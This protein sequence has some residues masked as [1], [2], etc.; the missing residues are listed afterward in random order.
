M[1]ARVVVQ[2]PEVIDW[3]G[4]WSPTTAY[5]PGDTVERN[6]SSYRAKDNTTGDD[7]E[8]VPAKWDLLAAKGDKGDQGDPGEPGTPGAP[9]SAPQAFV[10]EQS[11]AATIWIIPHALGYDPNYSAEDS[12]GTPMEGIPSWPVPGQVMH[13]TFLSAR[14]GTAR[15]S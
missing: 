7:P 9:G 13:I 5:V 15:L 11:P 4:P 8:L 2:E 6:G 3:E 12:A 1:T 10:W 14:G